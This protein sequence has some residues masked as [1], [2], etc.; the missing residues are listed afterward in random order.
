MLSIPKQAASAL[1]SSQPD[2]ANLMGVLPDNFKSI[3]PG[4]AKEDK[5]NSTPFFMS[6]DNGQLQHWRYKNGV[7]LTGVGTSSNGQ[8]YVGMTWG[9]DT[10]TTPQ[11]FLSLSPL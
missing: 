3:L 2:L 5:P 10:D 8:V 4:L 9:P 11:L 7:V 1:A 6:S